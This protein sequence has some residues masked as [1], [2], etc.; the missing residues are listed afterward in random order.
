M[1]VIFN[2]PRN[3]VDFFFVF[4][5]IKIP[6]KL[7]QTINIDEKPGFLIS[8]SFPK[9]I[10]STSYE[11]LIWEQP[12]LS[13]YS[14]INDGEWIKTIQLKYPAEVGDSWELSDSTYRET[15]TLKSK[16]YKL[17]TP[18]GVFENCYYYNVFN[19]DSNYEI[20]VK[21]GIGILKRQP[22]ILTAYYLN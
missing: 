7:T 1:P 11:G 21:P 22:Q 4:V 6:K 17:D 19:G 5:S 8:I 20:F 18:A 2:N 16:T 9:P 3:S 13:I 15:Y 12:F 14:F 10:L